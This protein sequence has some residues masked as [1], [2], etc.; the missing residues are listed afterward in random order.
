I[1]GLPAATC[2]TPESRRHNRQSSRSTRSSRP[3][4]PVKP[5]RSAFRWLLGGEASAP[6]RATAQTAA[7]P[8]P[9][10]SIRA[11]T[12]RLVFPAPTFSPFALPIAPSPSYDLSFRKPVFAPG[13]VHDTQVPEAPW[14]ASPQHASSPLPCPAPAPLSS[15]KMAAHR[16]RVPRSARKPAHRGLLADGNETLLPI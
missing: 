14:Q 16:S 4:L 10:Y 12:R 1:P 5:P 2:P 6:H 3:V 11:P 8:T 13:S 7:L 15:A 9:D